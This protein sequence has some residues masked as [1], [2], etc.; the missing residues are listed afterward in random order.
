MTLLHEIA[1]PRPRPGSFCLFDYGFRPFFLAAGLQAASSIPLWL[2]RWF[3]VT[4]LDTRWDPLQLH[5]HEML[6]GF[7]AAALAGFFLTAVPNWTGAAAVRGKPLMLLAALWLAARILAYA[8]G[9]LGAWLF[10]IADLAFLPALALLVAPTILRSQARRNAVFLLLLLLLFLA[11]LAMHATALG[12]PASWGASGLRLAIGLFLLLITLVGGRILPAF[13][14]SGLKLSGRKAELK[15]WP[16]LDVAAILATAGF[17][18]AY[19]V[20]AEGPIVGVVAAAAAAIHLVRLSRWQGWRATALPL[21]WVLHLAYFWLVLGLALMALAQFGEA[22]P[23]DA[24]LHAL[25]A[26]AIGMMILAV[27]TRAALGHTGRPLV[28]HRLTV[29]AYALVA[30]GAAVRAMAGFLGGEGAVHAI[31]TGGTLW[32]LGFLL[33]LIVYA[34]ILVGCRADGKPG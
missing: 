33:F 25:T 27:M 7:A 5:A 1:E 17:A 22:V 12:L 26:G 16:G 3:G 14:V 31:A 32:A 18:I 11:N 30:V 6:Y 21:L 10:A 23:A 34:P 28:A 9:G 24:A 20:F 15:P 19:A 29:A 8:G 13:T 4:T 2:L